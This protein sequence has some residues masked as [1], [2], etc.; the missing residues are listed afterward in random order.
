REVVVLED[1]SLGSNVSRPANP[2]VATFFDGRVCSADYWSEEPAI[3]SA[4]LGFSDII[5]VAAPALTED[6]ARAAGGAWSSDIDCGADTGNYTSTSIQSQVAQVYV[7]RTPYGQLKD[8]ALGIDGLPIV[9]SWP[10]D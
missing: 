7:M 3:L 8:G 6:V 2:V 1:E 10:V 4:G 9:F 5:G